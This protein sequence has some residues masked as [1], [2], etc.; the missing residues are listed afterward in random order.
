[1][2]AEVIETISTKRGLIHPGHFIE[3]PDEIAAMLGGKI[4]E[5]SP[6]CSPTKRIRNIIEGSVAEIGR[7]DCASVMDMFGSIETFDRK[8]CNELF[9]VE[10]NVA[11]IAGNEEKTRKL[12]GEYRDLIMKNIKEEK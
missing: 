5:V 6:G 1:M 12:L 4:R 8:R 9:S 3:I 7:L 11:A 2:L 10:I